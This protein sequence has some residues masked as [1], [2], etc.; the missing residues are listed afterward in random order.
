MVN[1]AVKVANVEAV[2]HR[3]EAVGATMCH[4]AMVAMEMH[5]GSRR[6]RGQC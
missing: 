5:R 2:T 3:T 1:V 6:G 4:G